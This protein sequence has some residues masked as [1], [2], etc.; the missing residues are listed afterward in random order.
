MKNTKVIT[1]FILGFAL[2]ATYILCFGFTIDPT[3][4]GAMISG[5]IGVI[6]TILWDR[7]AKKASKE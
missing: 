4:L 7:K 3:L 5:F 2:I 1:L 6:I